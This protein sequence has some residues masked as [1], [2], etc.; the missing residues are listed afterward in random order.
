[1]RGRWQLPESERWLGGKDAV[2]AAYLTAPYAYATDSQGWLKHNCAS[3][4]GGLRGER[5]ALLDTLTDKEVRLVKDQRNTPTKNGFAGAG[6]IVR[7]AEVGVEVPRRIMRKAP[8]NTRVSIV[9]RSGGGVR[10]E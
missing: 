10:V 2:C 1:M 8:R 3:I 9:E 5:R 6:E 4:G 7:K